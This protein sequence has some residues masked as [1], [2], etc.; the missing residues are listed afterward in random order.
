VKQFAFQVYFSGPKLAF[1]LDSVFF[2]FRFDKFLLLF[3]LDLL[4]YFYINLVRL[5]SALCPDYFWPDRLARVK[6]D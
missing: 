6:S 3:L 1:V 5:E 4:L 2:L